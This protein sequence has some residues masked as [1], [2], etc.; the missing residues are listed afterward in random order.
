MKTSR[1]ECCD[2]TASVA[3]GYVYEDERPRGVYFLDWTEGHPDRRAFLSVSLGEWGEEASGQDR[4]L[5][6]LEVQRDDHGQVGFRLAENPLRQSDFLGEFMPREQILA[7]GG[8]AHFWHITDH[9][10]VDDPHA[11]AVMDWIRG[12]RET[13]AT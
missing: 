13:A 12:D 1:C 5:L 4:S 11:A 9:I 2:G 8:L 6:G 7:I 3:N 10:A